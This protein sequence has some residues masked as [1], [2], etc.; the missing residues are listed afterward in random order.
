MDAQQGAKPQNHSGSPEVQ[1]AALGRLD[2][3]SYQRLSA[4]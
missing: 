4:A 3:V 2:T 1:A